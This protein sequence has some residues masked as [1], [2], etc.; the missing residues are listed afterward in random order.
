MIV[1]GKVFMAG[2][3]NAVKCAISKIIKRVQL[4]NLH[5]LILYASTSKQK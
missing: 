2:R 4:K 1:G 5:K 3:G